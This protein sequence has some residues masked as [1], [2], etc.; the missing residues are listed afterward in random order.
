MKDIHFSVGDDFVLVSKKEL[1]DF[2]KGKDY[3]KVEFEAELAFILKGEEYYCG[4]EFLKEGIYYDNV[5]ENCYLSTSIFINSE[6]THM[7]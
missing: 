6:F 3:Y 1:Y 2:L 5:K 7:S 4:V